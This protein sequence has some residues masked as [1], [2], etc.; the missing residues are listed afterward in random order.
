MLT[1]QRPNWQGLL[2]LLATPE[3]ASAIAR[4]AEAGLPLRASADMGEQLG[5]AL[6]AYPMT[7]EATAHVHAALRAIEFV[8]ED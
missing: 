8:E 1:M 3:V 4:L 2:A 7:V 5:N 6:G